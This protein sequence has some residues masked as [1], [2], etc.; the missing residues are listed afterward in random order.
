MS[1]VSVTVPET[2]PVVMLPVPSMLPTVSVAS[3]L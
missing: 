2:A 3:T 1:A